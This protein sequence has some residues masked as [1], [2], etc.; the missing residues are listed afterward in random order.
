MADGGRHDRDVCADHQLQMAEPP[1][2]TWRAGPESVVRPACFD[3]TATCFWEPPTRAGCHR[4][5]AGITGDRA[6]L[7]V[8]TPTTVLRHAPIHQRI[9]RR[10]LSA[11]VRRPG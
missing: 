10:G 5:S 8:Q 2:F 11:G 3:R 7:D 9:Y 6:K 4:Q 1:S